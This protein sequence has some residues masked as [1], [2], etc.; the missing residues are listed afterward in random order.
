[1][2]KLENKVA[3]V[4]GGSS[5]I[6]LAIARAFRQHGARVAIFGRDRSRLE[7]AV[8]HLQNGTLAVPGDVAK[9]DD[10]DRLFAQ[11]HA[12]FGK[13]DVLV[14][15]AGA[16]R[17]VPFKEVDE[18]LFDRLVDVNVKGVFFTVQRALPYLRDGASVLLVS[19]V[20]HHKGFPDMSVYSA[21][22]AAVRSL[23]RTLSA[24]LLQARGIRINVLSPG[25]VDT[26]FVRNAGV[27]EEA[28]PAMKEAFASAVPL[29]RWGTAEE[30]AQAGLFLASS[31]SSYIVGA[32]LVV[33]GGMSQL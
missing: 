8:A 15:N 9:L 21:A 10:L 19:S 12:R 17:F 24:E 3:V 11:V 6:G 22:K 5:G 26:P 31:D 2:K 30:V 20:A 13:I 1:M 16:T 29:G 23:A 7:A 25:P 27:P 18:S 4:T 33:D 32:E 14:A 28:V